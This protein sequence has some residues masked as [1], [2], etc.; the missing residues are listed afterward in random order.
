MR[1]R[2]Q[3]TGFWVQGRRLRVGIRA[4]RPSVAKIPMGPGL[5]LLVEQDLVAGPPPVFLAYEPQPSQVNPI[6]PKA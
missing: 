6:S 4:N 1:F 5:F 3:G 2:V